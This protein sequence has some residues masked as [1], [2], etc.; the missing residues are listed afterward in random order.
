MQIQQKE[1][2]RVQRAVSIKGMQ[3]VEQ[4]VIERKERAE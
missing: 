1:V 3:V 2:T 4:Q